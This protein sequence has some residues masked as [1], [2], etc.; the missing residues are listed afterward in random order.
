MGWRS[1]SYIE[2]KH[3]A[4]S[5]VSVENVNEDILHK[6]QRGYARILGSPVEMKH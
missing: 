2:M 6:L 5:I 3:K 1:Y 4:M